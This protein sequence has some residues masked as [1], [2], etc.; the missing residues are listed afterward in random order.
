[1][2][3][4][5]LGRLARLLGG[6]V[7]TQGRL[8]H[9][10]LGQ[11]L[12]LDTDEVAIAGATVVVAATSRQRNA[13]AQAAIRT[14]VPALA[15]RGLLHGDEKRLEKLRDLVETKEHAIER[16]ARIRILADERRLRRGAIGTA[17]LLDAQGKPQAAALERAAGRHQAIAPVPKRAPLAL[18]PATRPPAARAKRTRR[19]KGPKRRKR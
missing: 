19:P 14:A 5:P 8:G 12:L 2:A 15:V 18:P 16:L 4:N 17:A 13:I 1:L 3:E 7:L 9:Q 11:L 10:V 6:V